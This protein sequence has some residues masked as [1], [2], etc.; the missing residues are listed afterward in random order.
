METKLKV[1]DY[2]SSR[3][4]FV[5]FCNCVNFFSDTISFSVNFCNN[6]DMKL[7]GCGGLTYRGIICRM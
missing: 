2:I 6:N 1:V 4:K 7:V 3:F 5:N